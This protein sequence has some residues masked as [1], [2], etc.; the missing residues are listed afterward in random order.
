MILDF[1]IDKVVAA[2]VVIVAVGGLV[3]VVIKTFV[4]A[5]K[6]KQEKELELEQPYFE[7]QIFEYKAT[8]IEKYCQVEGYGSVKMPQTRNSFYLA[9]KTYDGRILKYNVLEQ[10]YLQ[11]EEGQ[12]GT[13]AIVNDNF[14]GFCP[15]EET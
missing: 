12:S 8:V 5:H 15:D 13:L 11:I 4:D 2:L 9:F 1:N 6:Q 7:P 10:D 14:Y 3:T